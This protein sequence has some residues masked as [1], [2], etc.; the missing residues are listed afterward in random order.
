MDSAWSPRSGTPAITSFGQISTEV[1]LGWQ[2][3]LQGNSSWEVLPVSESPPNKLKCQAS[4]T[5]GTSANLPDEKT[6]VCF[7]LRVL[8]ESCKSPP[9]DPCPAR[10]LQ[11]PP[12]RSMSCKS[13]PRA[14]QKIHVLQEC[15]KRAPKDHLKFIF[16]TWTFLGR[17]F[18]GHGSFGGLLQ[19][20]CRTWIFWGAFAGLLQDS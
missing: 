1:P 12:K 13:A 11:K 8:Q 14:P 3:T 19:D 16:R 5:P 4:G 9:K 15:C 6:C 20:S 10:V 17:P 2:K 18:E 7:F